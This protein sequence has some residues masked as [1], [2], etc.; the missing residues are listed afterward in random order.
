MDS[1][2][3]LF[4]AGLIGAIALLVFLFF[5]LPPLLRYYVRSTGQPAKAT[6]LQIRFGRWTVHSGGEHSQNVSAQQV[7][8]RLEVHPPNDAP[9]IAED[10]FMAKALDLMRLN[11]GCEIQVFIARNNPKRVV[12]LPNTVTAASN[13]PVAAR[14]GLAM[15][16]F[17]EQAS[18]GGLVGAEQVLEALR[19]QGIQPAPPVAEDDP[20]VKIEKLKDMLNSALITQAEFESKKKEILARM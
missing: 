20:Q 13:A 19:A 3:M 14:A 17:A 15:A 18:R 4:V 5:G 1:T 11:E 7:I 8:L 12:C 6:I 10:K 9:Y 2:T 16:S